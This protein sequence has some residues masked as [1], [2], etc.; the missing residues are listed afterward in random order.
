MLIS[1]LANEDIKLFEP[2]V[3]GYLIKTFLDSLNY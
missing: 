2:F 3:V 1:D